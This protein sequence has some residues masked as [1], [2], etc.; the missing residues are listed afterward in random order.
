MPDPSPLGDLFLFV[1]ALAA[2][3]V[4]LGVVAFIVTGGIAPGGKN[5]KR[6]SS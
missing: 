3:F 2:I 6:G 1:L 5:Q 4:P